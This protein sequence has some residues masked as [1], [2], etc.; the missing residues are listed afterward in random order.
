MNP[1]ILLTYL[2]IVRLFVCISFWFWFFMKIIVSNMLSFDVLFFSIYDQPSN[3]LFRGLL[4]SSL[5]PLIPKN[6][7]FNCFFQHKVYHIN[8]FLY[9][10]HIVKKIYFKEKFNASFLIL[11]ISSS[12][13]PSFLDL[14]LSFSF[15]FS[16]QVSI[17]RLASRP[18]DVQRI[19]WF[20]HPWK[21]DISLSTR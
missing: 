20:A 21:M 7:F 18:Q 4:P 9:Y 13:F 15:S 14:C 6:D 5:W 3:N 16:F 1:S 12:F 11:F 8:S 19:S 17:W 10:F 2:N